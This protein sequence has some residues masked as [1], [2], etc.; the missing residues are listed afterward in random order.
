MKRRVAI[1]NIAILGT[2]SA[3]SFSTYKIFISNYAISVSSL[4]KMKKLVVSLTQA[5]I[6][7][8]S[9]QGASAEIIASFVIKMVKFCTTHKSQTNFI[10]GLSKVE[11]LSKDLYGQS[12]N[13]CTENQQ[14][15]ILNTLERKETNINGFTGKIYKKVFGDTFT[16]LLKEYTIKGYCTSQEGAT[17]GLRYIPIPGKYIGCTVLENNQRAWATN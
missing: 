16:K 9:V 2:L 6:P 7:E 13:N 3:I 12:F 10:K 11:D 5:I 1:K 4:D 14:I 15:N 8:T 17:K